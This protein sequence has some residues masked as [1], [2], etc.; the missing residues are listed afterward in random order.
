M[1]P[2]E[3]RVEKV[4]K[5][6]FETDNFINLSRDVSPEWDSLKH[7][8]L[9]LELEDEFV[10]EFTNSASL[11]ICNFDSCVKILLEIL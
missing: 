5:K 8:E 7:I 9:V 3:K 4:F 11:E 10:I 6:V 1:I 2:A